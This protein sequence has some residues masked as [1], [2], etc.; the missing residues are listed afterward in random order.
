MFQVSLFGA[1]AVMDEGGF[2]RADLGSNARRLGAYLFTFPNRIHR[3]EHLLDLFWPETDP[4]RARPA[5]S[6][7]L[8]RVRRLL[9]EDSRTHIALR[10]T[11]HNVCLEL[12]DL[13]RIDA[14]HFRSATLDAFSANE[15]APD[16]DALERA[17]SLYSGPFLEEF[18]EDWVLDQRERLHA[19][20]I[21]VLSQLMHSFA[22]QKKFED[23]LLC[24]RRLLASDPMRETMHRAVMLLY[25]LNGQRGEAI[26]QFERCERVLRVECDVEPM[27]ETR[28]L[29][30]MVRSGEIFAKLP[31][32]TEEMLPSTSQNTLLMSSL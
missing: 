16:C 17:A 6:T 23:A 24:G 31:R 12:G 11:P 32:L 5:F 15:N 18:D 27:P 10:T 26:R 28:A 19:L 21:R 9:R 2:V 7:A 13:S 29:V 14:H 1:F 3:R 30:Q 25:I 4:V 8:W 20:Y 22:R